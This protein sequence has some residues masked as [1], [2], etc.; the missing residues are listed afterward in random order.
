MRF[1]R[2]LPFFRPAGRRTGILPMDR[3]EE[4]YLERRRSER[5][6]PKKERD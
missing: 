4:R 1:L 3:N 5:I 2:F 6:H